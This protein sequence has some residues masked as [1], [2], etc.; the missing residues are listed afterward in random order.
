MIDLR[1]TTIIPIWVVFLNKQ[2][3]LGKATQVF[4]SV[5]QTDKTLV[6][7]KVTDTLR[8]KFPAL[9]DAEMAWVVYK[10]GSQR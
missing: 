8:G 6:K 3:T 9:A 10:E 5:A 2:A 1:Q 7:F 4:P